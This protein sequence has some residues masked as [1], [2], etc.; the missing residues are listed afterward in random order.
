[1]RETIGRGLSFG[2][3]IALVQDTLRI[4]L[5]FND[6]IVFDAHQKPA[7]AVIHSGAMGSGPTH[8]WDSL[9]F[10]SIYGTQHRLS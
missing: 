10:D 5:Y 3:D 9:S 6:A 1:M 2:A 7:A 4:A 8:Q